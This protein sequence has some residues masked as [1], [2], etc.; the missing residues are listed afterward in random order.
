MNDELFLI[1]FVLI[2]STIIPILIVIISWLKTWKKVDVIMKEI[3]E[4]I[5]KY[6]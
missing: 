6:L 3:K 5:D 1:F 4:D 2:F